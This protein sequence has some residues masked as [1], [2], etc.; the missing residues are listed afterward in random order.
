MDFVELASGLEFPEGP[1]A[2]DDGS[3]LLTEIARGTL[4]RVTPDGRVEV[5]AETGGGPNGAAIGPDGHVW[6]TNNGGFEWD[7]TGGRL[8]PV[9][10]ARDYRT[11]SIQRVN[12][13][14]GAV[15]TVY[16]ECDGVPLKGPNDIVFDAAGGFWFSDL[17]KNREYDRDLGAL[18]YATTDG[19]RISRAV[20]PIPG[21]ANGVGLAPGDTHVYIAETP[22]GRL[23]G[24]EIAEPG[25]LAA[26]DAAAGFNAFIA[27]AGGYTLFDS[28]AVEESGNVC[29]AT[30]GPG[31]VTVID[32]A[33]GEVE[34]VAVG[35]DPLTTNICFGG[36]EMRT[37]YITLSTTGR[38]I[39]CEWPRPGLRL[40]FNA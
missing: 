33:T 1:I 26:D 21:G 13:A 18:Y 2:M 29:V 27:N 40:N 11:G 31:G 16:T 5:V 17:G 12:P 7:R 4:T 9:G 36:P 15:E 6:I 39:S 3:V 20:F 8:L 24:W 14:S 37:A 32:P 35:D 28:L 22:T 10:Q 25:V 34:H 38:L 30:I 23:F 19:S